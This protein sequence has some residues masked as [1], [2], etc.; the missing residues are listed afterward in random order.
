MGKDLSRSID[1]LETRTDIDTSKLGFYGYSWGGRLGG[2]IPAVEERLKV[3]VLVIGGFNF[4]TTNWPY[5]EA[6]ELNYVSRV[7]IPVLMLNGKF[8]Y[9]F[10]LETT[11][12]PFFDLLGTPEKDKLL[13]IYET[14]HYVP[15]SEMI[16]ETLNWLDKYLGPVK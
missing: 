4:R 6:E 7:K 14:D 9:N 5:P 1:Y 12:K 10:P 11:V 2:I 8:D 3:S 15:K 13:K 16:K